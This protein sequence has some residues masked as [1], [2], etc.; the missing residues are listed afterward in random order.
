MKYNRIYINSRLA[1]NSKIEL[2]R[3]H[4]VHYVKTVL[5][6]KVN[7][8]LR[9]FNGTDGEFLAQINDI[10][11]NNLSVRLKEQLKKPYTE[12]TLTLA[13][14][15]IKQDK[16]M[17]AINMATQLGITK[18]IPLITRWCQFRSVNIERLTKCVIEA[19]EQSERLTPPII[20][21]AITIQDYLKKNNNLMLYANEHEKEENSILRISSSLSNSD[22]T[23]IVGP[24]GGFTNAELELLASYKNTKSISLGSNILRAETAAI[25]AIA[26]V[27]LLGSH[28]EEIA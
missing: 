26:Q 9:L 16:L 12:S 24:E 20:E 19:T 17:L 13:V 22:I 2:A 3:D 27:R 25:T 15:I 8:C 18:I 4:H 23:I 5:R 1:E 6:L 14:A 7:D 21:K 10:G 11:K 28:C